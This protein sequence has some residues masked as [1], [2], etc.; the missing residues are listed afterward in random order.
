MEVKPT[1]TPTLTL[2]LTLTL[3]G[4]DQ[5]YLM[6]QNK[7]RKKSR[8]EIELKGKTDQY[9]VQDLAAPGHYEA[10]LEIAG[11]PGIPEAIPEDMPD[12][13]PLKRVYDNSMMPLKV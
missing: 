5:Q 9:Q 12:P 1:L 4:G 6:S 3:V 8:I 13:E 2:T 10:S 7:S 11:I